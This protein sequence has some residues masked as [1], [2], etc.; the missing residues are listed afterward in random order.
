MDNL[1]FKSNDAAFTY[2]R[3][4]FGKSKLS[5]NSSFIGIVKFIDTNNEP[6]IYMIEITCKAGNF[7]KRK[8]TMLV[9]AMGHDLA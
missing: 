4:F 7:L 2:A 1:I 9:A 6:E 3:R 5:L 8:D